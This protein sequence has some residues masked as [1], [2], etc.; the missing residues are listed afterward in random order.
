LSDSPFAIVVGASSG[1]GSATARALASRGRSVH[2]LARR[3]DQL[4]AL[5]DELGGSWAVADVTSPADLTAALSAAVAEHGPPSFAVYSSGVLGRGALVEQSLDE[6]RAVLDVNLV[7]AV[8]FAKALV[9][10][11]EAGSRLVFVS[12]V[13]A[14][15]GLANLTAYSASKAGLS[16]F[17]QALQQEVEPLGIGVCVVEPGPTATDIL[18]PGLHPYQ[19]EPEHVGELVAGLA[20]VPCDVVL[21]AIEVRPVTEGPFARPRH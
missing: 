15:R 4:R 17:A 20:D 18:T 1:I 7:G 8:V 21:G 11:L 10:R 9:P 3:A 6:W 14:R 13:S 2:L 16:C 5:A 19:L 12:S